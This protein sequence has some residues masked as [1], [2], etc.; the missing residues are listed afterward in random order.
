[1]KTTHVLTIDLEGKNFTIEQAI[2]SRIHKIIK[3]LNS[4]KATGP[5]KIQLKVVKLSACITDSHFINNGIS[6][7]SF[8][9]LLKLLL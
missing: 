4:K 1:M 7:D 3:H 8:Q 6:R 2:F 5:E 9:I